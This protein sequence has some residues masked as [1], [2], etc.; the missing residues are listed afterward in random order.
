MFTLDVLSWLLHVIYMKDFDTIKEN[1][2]K[3]SK[4]VITYLTQKSKTYLYSDIIE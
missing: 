4:G 1:Q 2:I 3:S